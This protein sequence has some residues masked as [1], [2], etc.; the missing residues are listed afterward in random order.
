MQGSTSESSWEAV[1]RLRRVEEARYCADHPR[2][3]A[4]AETLG[5]HYFAGVPMHWMADWPQPFPL[6]VAS[7]QGTTIHDVDGHTYRDFC[8][9]D[10]GAMFGHSPPPVAAAIAE[11]AARG[12]TTLLP[13]A[14]AGWVGAELQ[15][16]FGLPR[17]Q[18]TT[19]ASDA[20]RFL[21]RW[22]RAATGREVIVVFDGCYHGAVDETL[23]RLHQDCVRHGP[24]LVG[25]AVDHTRTT[26]AVD[27]NDLAG[28]RRALAPGDV[29]AVLCEPVMTNIGMVLPTPDFHHELRAL[30]RQAGTLLLLD[31]THTLSTGPGGYTRAHDLAPDGLV[32]GKA[33]AGGLSCAVYGVTAVLAERMRAAWQAAGPGRTGIGTTLSAN[34]LQLAALRAN[35]EAVMTDAAYGSMISRA[36]TLADTL[37]RIMTA[38]R[39]PWSVTQLGARLEIQYHSGSPRTGR[40][41][42][43]AFRP[44]LSHALHLY[45][46]NRGVIVTPFHNMML[47]SPATSDDDMAV[48]TTAFEEFLCALR[49][50]PA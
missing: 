44:A 5:E 2:A 19:T 48:L 9:G 7:A 49:E 16:R 41:A 21:L 34:P 33:I 10:S 14:D 45:W 18:L 35:L 12:L 43:A 8:L 15:R 22:A 31:E 30:T 1:S 32:I 50:V 17:W 20:N 27:F 28:L 24:G 13:S 6:V 46:L 36:T 47:V 23:V 25:Q 39:L 29:A 4:L 37:R 42:E 3:R 38:H 40:E 26:R 11:Q